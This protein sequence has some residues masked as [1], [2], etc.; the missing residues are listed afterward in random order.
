MLVCALFHFD[1]TRAKAPVMLLIVDHTELTGCDTMD[2][3][4]SMDDIPS[5]TGMLN[6]SGEVFRCMTDLKRHPWL[7]YL[8]SQE[9]EVVNDEVLF[10]GCL[11][12]IAMA[13]IENILL[14]ILLYDKPRAAA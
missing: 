7:V 4:I 1:L 10:V 2:L 12:I 13:D 9:V 11:R 14:Y 5:F 3:F 8:S 6:R